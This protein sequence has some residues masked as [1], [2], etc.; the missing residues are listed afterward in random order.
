[1]PF[2]MTYCCESCRRVTELIYCK[3]ADEYL[4]EDCIMVLAEEY[5]EANKTEAPLQPQRTPYADDI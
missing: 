5:Y 3:S 2:K 4:C 1:M